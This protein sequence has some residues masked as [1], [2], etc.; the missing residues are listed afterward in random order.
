MDPRSAPQPLPE[1]A[2]AHRV[3]IVVDGATLEAVAGQTLA[4]VLA[5]QGI[6]TLRHHAVSREPRGP[7]CGMG[8]CFECE[9]EVDGAE[10]VRSCMVSV[11]QGMIVRTGA[12]QGG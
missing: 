11:A 7:Y 1:A 10:G 3:R 6:W 5:G 8:V 9:V 12:R 2:S 4:A